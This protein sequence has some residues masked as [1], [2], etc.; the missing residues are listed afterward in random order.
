MLESGLLFET[1]GELGEF[2]QVECNGI[3]KVVDINKRLSSVIHFEFTL[4]SEF[5]YTGPDLA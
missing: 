5:S 2:I 3:M 4:L 1:S